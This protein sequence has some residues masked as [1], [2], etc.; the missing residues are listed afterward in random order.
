MALMDF[1]D[2][3]GKG[4]T[5]S[6]ANPMPVEVA[7]IEIPPIEVGSV[8]VSNGPGAPV[9]VIQGFA[10]PLYDD[11]AL[12]DEEAPT[13][14]TYSLGGNV[15]ATVTLVYGEGGGLIGG[16]IAYPGG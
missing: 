5:V 4:R 16:S 3:D 15:V 9:P 11:F 2:G 10:L 12:D 6:T 7:G 8:E 1:I 13:E 14:I